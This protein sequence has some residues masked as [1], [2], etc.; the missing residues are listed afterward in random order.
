MSL[1]KTI[2]STKTI[3]I[4]IDV[5]N[6]KEVSYNNKQYIVCYIPFNNKEKLFVID[7]SQKK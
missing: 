7:E 2:K 3:Q 6:H 5:I 1:Q 4:E